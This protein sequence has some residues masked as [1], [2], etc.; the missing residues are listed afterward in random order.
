M[1]QDGAGEQADAASEVR[2]PPGQRRQGGDQEQAPGI[3]PV[4]TEQAGL[5]PEAQPLRD[6]GS[7]GA[8]GG[9]EAGR[10]LG[11][12]RV[13]DAIVP[14]RRLHDRAAEGL[15][16]L[17]QARAALVLGRKSRERRARSQRADRQGE[18]VVP[19]EGPGRRGDDG[20]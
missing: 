7:A 14:P 1:G 9:V 10:R 13:A 15:Q 3:G 12:G 19:L 11:P 20:A 5:G 17:A 8:E 2:A 16:R 18:G 6:L 4:P